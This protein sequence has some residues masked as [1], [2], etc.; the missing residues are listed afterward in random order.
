M[1]LL[2]KRSRNKEIALATLVELLVQF[3]FVFTLVLVASGVIKS[4]EP[5][6]VPTAPT[7]EAWRTLLS[8]F[9]IRPN[10]IPL[11]DQQVNA[12]R[13][14][15]QDLKQKLEQANK[16]AEELAQLLDVEKRRNADLERELA[17]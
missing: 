1:R 8:I 13:G 3:V 11:I 9:D 5:K 14:G 6:R 2:S 16:E 17:K 10:L 12:L 7:P 4:D 15:I